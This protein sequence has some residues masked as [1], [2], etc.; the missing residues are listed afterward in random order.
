M[1]IVMHRYGSICEPDLIE[2]FR[3]FQFTVIEE[4]SEIHQKAISPD[5]RISLI[6]EAILTH[7]PD[8]VFS[9][10]FFPYISEVCQR[11]NTLYV[12]LSVDCPVLEFF[13][14]SIRNKC[15][16][17]FLFDYNQYLQFKDENPDCIFYLP[18]GTN[19]DRWDAVFADSD[20]LPFLYD[21]SFVGSLYTEK[22]LYPTLTLSDFDRGFCDGLLQAQTKFPGLSLIEDT[23]TEETVSRIKAACGRFPSLPDTFCNTD[24]YV[25]AN[26]VL[27]MEIASMQRIYTLNLLATKF[28]VDLF[29]RSDVSPLKQVHC[30]GGVTTHTEMPLIFKQSKINLNITIPSIQTG[31]SQ[32]IWDVLGCGGFLLSNY[33][34]ELPEYFEIGTDLDA[35]ETP[36]ELI[37]KVNFYLSHEDIRLQIAEN[38]YRKV[39]EKHSVSRRVLEM[40]NIIF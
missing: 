6:A 29:T 22:S 24:S 40:I 7:K 11:L 25:S 34:M 23:L 2:A 16:R 20:S 14:V 15:N 19:T 13:S 31:L 8:F 38:G 21:I 35:Y 33:Q 1:K 17:I 3:S 27:G 39:K 12:C 5:K 10:N 37:E 18:L 9:I 36:D 28:P 32:R 26:Y 4:D 30:H